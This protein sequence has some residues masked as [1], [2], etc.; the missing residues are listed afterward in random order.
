MRKN[1]NKDA[2]SDAAPEEPKEEWVRVD[3]HGNP[4]EDQNPSAEE[5]LAKQIAAN[6][7]HAE[8]LG[9]VWAVI[10][11]Q[12][13]SP[14]LIGQVVATVIHEGGTRP[15]WQWTSSDKD[16]VLLAWPEDQPIRASVLMT[17]DKG[18]KLVPVSSAPLLEGLPNDLTVE[19]VHPWANAVDADVAVN[20]IDGKNPMWFY[21]PLYSR[22]RNDITPGITHTF[23]LSALALAMRKTV[24]DE[25][26]ISQ[27]PA[28]EVHAQAWLADNP[29]K[30]RVDVPPLKINVHNKHL[31]M[32]GRHF[33]EYQIR[34]VVEKLEACQLDK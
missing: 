31:I 19:D 2:S 25:V 20:M 4:L 29:D 12:V 3:E 34:G 18:G 6:R 30:K 21:D 23:L 7:T 13:P 27:G 32:P 9:D 8:A 24:L 17:G 16:Y 15:S 22:D 5:V 1:P 28:W 33:C 26:T 10:T 11:G 14:N